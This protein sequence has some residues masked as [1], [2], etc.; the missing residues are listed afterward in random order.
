MKVIH[1]IIVVVLLD[2]IF[3]LTGCSTMYIK[4]TPR[5]PSAKL[6]GKKIPVKVGLLMDTE[7]QGYH[8]YGRTDAELWSKLD[9][10]LGSASKR[11]FTESFM[12]VSKAVVLVDTRPPYSD[13]DKQ[14]IA[15]VVKPKIA[16]FSEKHSLWWRHVDYHADITYHIT[17]YGSNGEVL[18][19]R[20]YSAPG[21]VRGVQTSGPGDLP[22]DNYA[23]PAIMA[24]EIAVVNIIEDICKLNIGSR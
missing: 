9:Y 7:F 10:D 4:M 15:V 18:L 1:G 3:V 8:W 17:I 12:L 14:D 22:V 5:V 16:A 13:P 19:D 24:M 2:S 23:A 21:V 20:D 6:A 11:L